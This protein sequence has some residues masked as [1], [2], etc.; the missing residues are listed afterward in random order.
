M[1]NIVNYV[2]NGPSRNSDPAFDLDK[3]FNAYF[4]L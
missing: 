4:D 1:L 2:G 3:P